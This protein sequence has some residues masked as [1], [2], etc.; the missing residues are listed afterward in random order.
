MCNAF[1]VI[2]GCLVDAAASA[3]A[4]LVGWRLVMMMMMMIDGG[5]RQSND[6]LLLL[7]HFP[8]LN[9]CRPAAQMCLGSIFLVMIQI[10]DCS[11]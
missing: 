7:L 5:P 8:V 9:K 3:A 2:C 4:F 10:N 1:L 11:L 6:Q